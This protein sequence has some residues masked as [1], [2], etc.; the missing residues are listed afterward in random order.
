M[1]MVRHIWCPLLPLMADGV[2]G[3]CR[4]ISLIRKGNSTTLLP[5]ASA[6]LLKVLL[7][8]RLFHGSGIN[9]QRELSIHLASL[10][11]VRPLL[12][13]SSRDWL[14]VSAIWA[15]FRDRIL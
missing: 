1:L 5:V 15:S 11:L 6:M 14:D 2:M 9:V 4:R 3:L 8:R 10:R 7:M 12:A 13:S